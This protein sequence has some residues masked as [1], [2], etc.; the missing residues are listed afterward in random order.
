MVTA[1]GTAVRAIQLKSHKPT[2]EKRT[3]MVSSEEIAVSLKTQAIIAKC[4]TIPVTLSEEER[5]FTIEHQVIQIAPNILESLQNDYIRY[6]NTGTQPN[7]DYER[8]YFLSLQSE[9]AIDNLYEAVSR[10]DRLFPFIYETISQ[11]DLFD[12]SALIKLL[13]SEQFIVQKR[14]LKLAQTDKPF[15][16][17]DD[18][19][20]FSRLIEIIKSTF[21]VR[22]KYLEEKSKLTSN[23]KHK[24]QCECGTKNDKEALR[25]SQCERDIYGFIQGEFTP[26]MVIQLLESKKSILSKVFSK[27]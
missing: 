11:G 18:I 16:S 25:C 5:N 1:Y 10:H 14:A 20:I 19:S 3:A 8:K 9:I 17:S 13:A 24:W 27:E 22:A 23:I 12:Y 7:T 6:Q 26:D 15:Y 21:E 4:Q 2:S